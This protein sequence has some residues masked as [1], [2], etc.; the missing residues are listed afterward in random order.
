MKLLAIDIGTSRVK[1]A[2]FDESG[3]M[4]ALTSQRLDRAASP[5]TQDA[6]QWYSI[7]ASLLRQMTMQAKGGIDGI[8]LTGNMHALLGIS[9]SGIPVAPAVLWSDNSAIAESDE[10]NQRYRPYLLEHFGNSAI[11]VFTLPKVLQMKHLHE[12]LYHSTAAFLQS[13]DY[14]AY[15]LTGQLCT[16]FSDASGVLAMDL[17][18][19]QWAVECLT[20]L[21]VEPRKFPQ[22][23]PS[24][25]ICGHVTTNAARETGLPQGTPVIIGSGD[26]ASAALGSGV[27]DDSF[28]LTLG[29][30][31][32]LLATGRPG[33]G[34]SL[35]GKLFV[36]AH[37]DPTRELYLGSVPAGGFSF[38]WFAKMHNITMPQF[39]QEASKCELSMELPFYMPYILGK[40]A[41]YMDYHPDGAFLGLSANHTLGQLC[42]ATIF[43]ALCPLRQCAD[44]LE[45]L[46]AP[47]KNI[48]LQAL[49]CREPCVR[50][51]A[52]ALFPQNKLL[53]GN[54]EASLLGAAIIGAKALG[55]YPTMASAS[56]SMVKNKPFDMPQS[57]LAEQMFNRF[58]KM[59]E[60]IS[61]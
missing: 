11:P 1:C 27:G 25:A 54:S 15:R 55:A 29:T 24:D 2:I 48:V 7:T 13:K 28:S 18:T 16:D 5:N 39:F 8:V 57:L 47:R 44:L 30:A 53:P 35:T 38:E 41:P 23:L 46:S 52:G 36:F 40:G 3:N 61:K 21:G 26:L 19:R 37:A 51:A 17:E 50:T 22:I 32:Q 34:R 43:G 49:A 59:A 14:I 42:L 58:L 31:G 45:S 60:E 20:E 4:S 56:E 33:M 9:R 12:D 6:E 10:L